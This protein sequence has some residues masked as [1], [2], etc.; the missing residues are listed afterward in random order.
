MEEK[1][2]SSLVSVPAA[3][4]IGS[5]L[6]SVA[7]LISGGILKLNGF[8][9]GGVSPNPVVAG[10]SAQPV[11]T[12][13]PEN[14]GPVEV[15]VDDDPVTGDK[16]AKLTMIEFSD[17]ECPFCKRYFDTTYLE[18]MKNYVD[19]G[20]MKIVYRDL[21]LSFHQNAHKEAQAA[22]CAKDQGGDSAYF[23]FH[24]E[25]FTKTTS[26]G[27]GLSIEELPALASNVGL[28]G[29]LLK[30]CLES[31]K[32][33]E[34]VDKDIADA[35]KAG[36]DGTPSFFIGKSTPNGVISGVRIVGAQPFSAFKTVIEEQLSK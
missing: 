33:K 13:E 7:I 2:A 29:S 21:P 26:N 5:V 15:S 3:I 36:A 6:I 24:D 10:A 23:K 1:N 8:A 32:H 30:Q 22:N 19:T 16:N 20:K 14:T 12:P 35:S 27:T 9:K 28:N 31:G 25:M 4:I 34:E 17:Y 11:L 18:I